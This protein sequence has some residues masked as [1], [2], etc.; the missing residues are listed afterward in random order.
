MESTEVLNSEGKPEMTSAMLNVEEVGDALS[1]D[2]PAESGGDVLKLGC[3]NHA[4]SDFDLPP[5][6]QPRPS[7][8]VAA[9]VVPTPGSL[10]QD[11]DNIYRSDPENEAEDELGNYTLDMLGAQGVPET[12]LGDQQPMP[13]CIEYGESLPP[14]ISNYPENSWLTDATQ[15]QFPKLFANDSL[16]QPTLVA[17][18]WQNAEGWNI[19]MVPVNE[20]MVTML[21]E[22]K[23]DGDPGTTSRDLQEPPTL[24]PVADSAV[25]TDCV[26]V[27]AEVST[28][29]D[30]ERYMNEV[31]AEREILKDKYQEVLDRQTQVENQLQIKVRCLQQQQEEEENIYQDNV[32]QI[33]EMKVKLEELK[34]KSEKEKKEFTQKE[35][36]LKNEVERLYENGKRLMKEQE[37][38]G[39]QVAILISSQSD[40]KEKLNEDLAKLQLQHNKLNRNILEETERALKAEVQSL[41]TKREIAVMVLDQAANEA[42]LQLCNLRSAAGSSNLAREWQRRLNDIQV[43]TENV[44]NQYKGHIQM[45]KNGA[46]LNSLPPI[47]M[48]TL[49]PLPAEA[50]LLSHSNWQ[51]TPT[52]PHFFPSS[53]PPLAAFPPVAFYAQQ[54][55]PTPGF[56]MG[57]GRT[58]D[59]ENRGA[60]AVVSSAS[61]LEKLLSKLESKFPNCSR[62]QLTH[63]LQQIKTSRGTIAGLSV[64]ELIQQIAECLSVSNQSLPSAPPG[65]SVS[66]PGRF[67]PAVVRTSPYMSLPKSRSGTLPSY[68]ERP[69][70]VPG[71]P[72]LC[73]MCQKVVPVSEVHPMA[74]LHI[75]HKEC[76]KFW[77]QTN[78]NSSCPFCPTPR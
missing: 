43:Q 69:A 50:D 49:P 46:K 2:V 51:S 6:D 32:K 63:I 77:A 4:Q 59:V 54:V 30:V 20:G 40:K 74:C 1:T 13:C 67:P 16:G 17:G 21:Y 65:V 75:V 57:L 3:E 23:P 25:Q 56:P 73:L 53:M 22:E 35:Q 12:V 45:V 19:G 36:E 24:K 68:Q 7:T 15:S 78:K 34:R 26:A 10:S 41:E 31:T 58:S 48:P 55:L 14:D 42:K 76:I 64:E 28:D 61:K 8:E 11:I 70:L 37:E 9:V 66:L 5:P 52:L 44:K 39:K 47:Q 33:K 62:K 71:S 29:Q 27:D 72:R 38:K 18:Y 60:P